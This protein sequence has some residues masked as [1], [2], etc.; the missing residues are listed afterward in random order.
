MG[1]ERAEP[2]ARRKV[3][4]LVSYVAT[5]VA[6]GAFLTAVPQEIAHAANTVAFTPKFQ[7]NANGALLS[8]GNNLLT[9]PG[10]ATADRIHC[11]DARNGAVIDNNSYHMRRLD[12]DS[13]ASTFN[14]SSSQLD[15]P[16]GSTVLWAGLYWG[17][18]LE[19]GS[20]GSGASAADIDQMLLQVPGGSYQT[21]VASTAAHDQ[22]GPNNSSYNAYQRFADVTSL[23]QAAGNGAYWG[24]N[25]AAAT[26]QDRYAG[27]ALTIAY[28]APGLPLRNL[29]VF[30]G[31]DVVSSGQPQTVNISG[32]LAPAAGTVDAQLTML[33]YEG[34]LSQTGDFTRL[35]NTQLA[36]ATSPG[37]NFFDSV[38]A[39]NGTSV[40]TRTPADRN[41]L[42]FDIKN[43][44]ASGAIPNSATSA[45]FTFSSN[46]DVY[47]PGVVGLAI[48]LYAPDFTASSKSVVN[49]D[50]NSPSRPG[51]TLQ[52]TLNYAN[53]GQD[54]AVGVV[55]TDVLPP[56]TTYVPGS[57]ALV[58]PLTGAT[59][60]LSDAGDGD[61]GEIDGRTVRVRLG[62]GA[63][64][65]TGGR[66]ACSGTGCA[67]NGTSRQSYTFQV[68]LDDAAGGTTVTN[69]ANL[70]YRTE[71]TDTSATYTT[72][73]ASVDVVQQADVS[74]VKTMTPSPAAVGSTVTATLEVANDGPNAATGVVVTDP[75]PGGWNGV[76]AATSQGSCA[77]GGGTVTCD[78][79]N[80]P[81][82]GTATITLTG[83][84]SPSST[85]TTLTNVATVVTTAFDPDPADNISGASIALNRQADLSLTKT[86]VT[87]TGVAGEQ[88]TWT[89]TV[90][91]GTASDA[92]NVRI[93][94]AFDVAGLAN[95]TD[96]TI[97]GGTGGSCTDPVGRSVRCA[98][99]TLPAGATA[100]VTITG[101]LATNLP[102]GTDVVNAAR[103][104]S[105]TPDPT[106]G[107][108]A[109]SATVT[110]TAPQADVRVTKTGPDSVVAGTQVSY[111]VTATNFG[112]SDADD[113]VI[114][115]PLPAGVTPVS[116]QPSRGTCTIAG[117]VV[118]CTGIGTLLSNGPGVAG[119]SV[120][121]TVVGTV[122][123]GATGSLSN[124]A[125][126]TTSTTDPAPG[127][128][129]ATATTAVT[130]S[131][132]VA[133]SK[134]ANRSTIPGEPSTIPYVIAV[135]NNG[136]STARDVAVRDLVPL[137]LDLDGVTTSGAP[138]TCDTTQAGTPQPAPDQDQGLVTCQIPEL[139]PGEQVTIT[140]TMSTDEPLSDDPT[141]TEIVETVEIAAAGDTDATDNEAT[142]T[143]QGT[144]TTDLSIT[145][146]APATAYAGS[147]PPG[148][149]LNPSYTLTVT[150]NTP[151]GE[152]DDLDAV[153]PVVVDTLP[154]GVGLRG[155]VGAVTAAIGDQGVPVACDLE[156]QTLT[157]QLGENLDA[158]ATVTLTVPVAIGDDVPAGTTLVNNASVDTG[159]PVANP[160]NNLSN[161]T[162]QAS[163]AVLT[164]ADPFVGGLA[165]QPFDPDHT[166]PGSSW[167]MSFDVGNNGPST[168]RDTQ[169]RIG[170]DV[171][172]AWVSPATLGNLPDGCDVVNLE[173]V[174]PI[175][176][177]G[178]GESQ[179]YT[180]EFVVTGYA[181]PGAYPGYVQVS[182]STQE[183]DQ[184]VPGHNTPPVLLNNRAQT[185]FTV[186]PA[187]TDLTVTKSALDTTP[188]PDEPADPH[189]S[190]V[191]G[192]PFTYQV[193]VRVPDQAPGEVVAGNTGLADAED[194][195]VTD[196]LPLGFIAQQA[197]APGGAC[198]IAQPADPTTG[199]YVVTCPLGTVAGFAGSTPAQPA[200]VTVHGVLHP[201]A[202][203]LNGGDRFAEQVANTAVATTGTPLLDGA[204]EVSDTVAVDVVEIADLQIVKTPESGTVN[205]GGSIGYTLT[206]V[207]AG[208]SGVEHAVIT[209]RLPV[210]FTL[211]DPDGSDCPP[212]Q[213][214]P[215]DE[216]QA[217]P[218]VP[219]GPGQRIACRVGAVPAGESRSVHVV[220]T[221]DAT[222]GATTA[223]NTATVG[224][225][226]NDGDLGNNTVAA[227]VAVARLT[228]LGI[229]AAVSTSTPAAGEQITFTGFA[230]NNGPSTAVGTSGDTV[231]PRGFVPVPDGVRVPFNDCTWSPD[232]PE[233][234]ETEP[235]RDIAYTLHCE[236]QTP[237][238]A[239]EPGGAAT[240]VVV[241]HV[242][243]DT[244]SGAYSGTS[245]I[246]SSTPEVALE[247][248]RTT[249]TVFVQRVS[250]TSIR[251]TLVRPH[252]MVAGQQATWRLTIHNNGP[253]VANNTVISDT[254]PDGMRF[255]SATNGA[256]ESC[257]APEVHDTETIVKCPMGSLRVGE[258]A[259]ALVTFDVAAG[260]A[261]S[262]L[263]NGALVGS[264]SLDPIA[265]DDPEDDAYSDNE[266]RACDPVVAGPEEPGQPGSVDTDVGVRVQAQ[267]Q[268]VRPGGTARFTAVV[269]NHGPGTA[270]DV[271]VRMP[272]P[273]GLRNVSAPGCEVV[274]ARQARAA[275]VLV[276]EVGT[277]APGQRVTLRV[278]GTVTAPAGSQ[279]RLRATVSSAEPDT[280]P[281]NDTSRDAVPV[282]SA[283]DG[284]DPG[285]GP[286]DEPGDGP[287]D[288]SGGPSGGNLPGDGPLPGT[289]GPALALLLAGLGAVVLGLG[290]VVVG[291]RRRS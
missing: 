286:S 276:C 71:T 279:V 267:Q 223:T 244:P 191:A 207:N 193:A 251:K 209:D 122:G 225:L 39:L 13:S 281:A 206:V 233:D 238:A 218:Q 166:G 173:L 4:R 258:T 157:C 208:P 62:S 240:N 12:A 138:A 24:A 120:S 128:N 94:D 114:T 37:S 186:G 55:S 125:T 104:A 5:L 53:T 289:G 162:A 182:T 106:P 137:V 119:G 259:S 56:N 226:A 25:V 132:D 230:V 38:N 134:T 16:A 72:N 29:S 260:A 216:T 115:D 142:W 146:D 178:F 61:R 159:A 97:T 201:D 130:S 118:T 43:L 88:V 168:A 215:V 102:A 163:T 131:Y 70:D 89:L 105:D 23:V 116:A 135:V 36:T 63:T 152:A 189:P 231:F 59:T 28:S 227:E 156:G 41:M 210:G 291:R 232:P 50:G 248:N 75:V 8:I 30:D 161:N 33:A 171:L 149:P 200:V 254:V 250:D 242:P 34:D 284:P 31:F 194:V 82:N 65:A 21:I 91:N 44:G 49:V 74:V 51:D 252:P 205:A 174:C 282:R 199:R 22:F 54:P 183:F 96:A 222:M 90:S 129:S 228:D 78:L 19:A 256:G 76:S 98:L 148:S 2:D 262:Q 219:D 270:T 211:D 247:N 278:S 170:L 196:E 60:P 268:R 153:A 266:A 67:D 143:L 58:N 190:F 26:G 77:V 79:G 150:N 239:W 139:A 165:I 17:A 229:S 180:F 111:T 6:L 93:D 288:D 224:L 272:V 213:T 86:P 274:A 18:R 164:L 285:G 198:D 15:L 249:E 220:A 154:D 69:L 245:T 195:V 234:P 20:G 3:R 265:V 160:D 64:G 175:G 7:A 290:L 192:G 126:A 52:Y 45:R 243:G 273:D 275:R 253:S 27:W 181:D 217:A 46:G 133:V 57:L 280:N 158:G 121:V 177:L 204:S 80:L 10:E 271:V 172:D 81:D 151:P 123:A 103:V 246:R 212:P 68:T 169:L 269:R 136:P 108:N 176:D 255:V 127:N 221:T 99:A 110:T 9:C 264:G 92:V 117:Q 112:P 197:T 155:G 179:A 185:S 203:N 140:V 84:T 109:D 188:N 32:F 85:A 141:I 187:V 40:T 47:Y 124:T 48:N 167:T 107:N 100:T 235:W 11:S 236:P 214:T 287:D 35:N 83:T 113:L 101:V 277:L 184:D 241:M 14:S 42:G 263:C 261:G 147:F 237:G 144:P 95:I 283:D 87:Q 1:D 73:P 257:P 66:M 202:N 145:K